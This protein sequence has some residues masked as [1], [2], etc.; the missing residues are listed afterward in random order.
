MCHSLPAPSDS[1][2]RPGMSSPNCFLEADMKPYDSLKTHPNVT[3]ALTRSKIHPVHQA[4]LHFYLAMSHDTMAR[5]ASLKHRSSELDL[6][7]QHYLAA[8]AALT[9][10]GP[11]RLDDIPERSPTSPASEDE[12]AVKARRVS[13]AS[14]Q[15]I[16]SSATSCSEHEYDANPKSVNSVKTS[17][18]ARDTK[19]E[20]TA[21]KRLVKRPAPIF[22]PNASRSYHEEN[23]SS[24]LSSFLGMVRMH[25]TRVQELKA[26]SVVPTVRFSFSRSRSSTSSSR[27]VSRDSSNYD[28]SER[29]S[30]RWARKSVNFRPRFDPTSVQKLCTEALSEL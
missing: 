14:Q 27:P 10:A 5:E 2:T 17:V 12:N 11:E 21:T 28:A 9:P 3:F 16:A 29:N 30:L 6:A 4:Y 26:D 7:E 1:R 18:L 8:I 13:D 19:T 24:D 15:S 23:F 22:T 25:L 20:A